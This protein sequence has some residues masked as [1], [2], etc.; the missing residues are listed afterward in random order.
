[1]G[2]LER[3]FLRITPIIM[4][5]CFICFGITHIFGNRN[6]NGQHLTYLENNK[7]LLNNPEQDGYVNSIV[8]YKFNVEEYIENAS[9]KTLIEGLQKSAD[10]QGWVN[11]IN[12]FKT[13]WENGYNAGDIALSVVNGCILIVNSIITLINFTLIPI[14]LSAAIFLTAISIMGV[15]INYDGTIINALKLMINSTTIPNI[16]PLLPTGQSIYYLQTYKF[17]DSFI[18]FKE[19]LIIDVNFECDNETYNR[20]YWG[21]NGKIEY[22]KIFTV[23]PNTTE[24]TTT[25]YIPTTWVWPTYQTITI[26]DQKIEDKTQDKLNKI[27]QWAEPIYE[28]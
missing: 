24:E 20:I 14:R 17:Y 19:K 27:L 4:L 7:I 9:T 26:L 1:M 22:V 3:F 28:E 18:V 13:I 6:Q 8:E 10:F 12:A 2:G 15:N 5:I 16:E 21:M 11:N 25:V 23:G